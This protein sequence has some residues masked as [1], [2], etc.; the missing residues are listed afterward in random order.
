MKTIALPSGERVPALGMGTWPHAQKKFHGG[1]LGYVMSNRMGDKKP[2]RRRAGWVVRGRY[3]LELR[4][5]RSSSSRN[6]GG[7]ALASRLPIVGLFAAL[8]SEEHT[9]E[10]QS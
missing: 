5:K 7:V 4:A 3:F 6:S 9:S 2:A 10:L 1:Q 8:R